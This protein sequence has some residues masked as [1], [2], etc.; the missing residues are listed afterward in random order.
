MG[1]RLLCC[2][3]LCLLGTVPMDS[4]IT[5]NPK[6]L[7]MGMRNK[8]CLQ[9]DQHLGYDYMYW[10]KQKKSEILKDRFSAERHDGS[11][12]TLKIQLTELG[13]SAIYLCASSVTTASQGHFQPVHKPS[14]FCLFTATSTT[15]LP[16]R[17]KS[18]WACFFSCLQ[19]N[20]YLKLNYQ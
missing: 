12:S 9:C 11:F 4:G 19:I 14:C 18:D 8:K 20:K 2:V 16:K 7:V 10:Y 1:C 3:A 13:D 5:Q 17:R 6:H 15:F